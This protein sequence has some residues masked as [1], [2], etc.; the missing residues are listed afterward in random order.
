MKQPIKASLT[1]KSL[2]IVIFLTGFSFET[3]AQGSI[4]TNFSRWDSK[5]IKQSCILDGRY[6]QSKF[7]YEPCSKYI[8]ESNMPDSLIKMPGKKIGPGTKAVQAFKIYTS[9]LWYIVS[10]PSRINKRSL[11]VLGGVLAVGGVMFAYDEKI[12]RA[13]DRNRSDDIYKFFTDAADIVEPMGVSMYTIPASFGSFAIGYALKLKTMQD[14]SIQIFESLMIATTIKNI[15]ANSVGRAR[16]N[17]GK[18]ARFSKFGGSASF[19]SGHTSNA[20]QVAR[21]LSHH[22]DSLPFKLL[23]YSSVALVGLHRLDNEMHWASDIF[24]GAVY[25]FTVSSAILKL[26]EKRKLMVTPSITSDHRFWGL[27]VTYE[28]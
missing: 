14:I 1:L 10:A 9:D 23:C 17:S 4:N 3:I 26:H 5:K 13:V 7:P 15:I 22:V 19:F 24:V 8:F 2:L 28:F 12:S 18:G 25:G 11:P 27:R 20:I 6:K 21:I 16:P